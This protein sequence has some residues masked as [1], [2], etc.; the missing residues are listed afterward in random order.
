MGQPVELGN[1]GFDDGML[2]SHEA[3]QCGELQVAESLHLVGNVRSGIVHEVEE[4][5][6]HGGSP[7][8]VS[9]VAR[10]RGLSCT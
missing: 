3:Q 8:L 5:T 4:V 1:M 6:S 10:V 9:G 2:L 7:P